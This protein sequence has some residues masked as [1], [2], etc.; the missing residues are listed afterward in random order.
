MG[1][2][3]TDDQIEEAIKALERHSPSIFERMKKMMMAT[4]LTSPL[5][6][7]QEK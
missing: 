4:T 3:H 7:E 6:D 2:F 5:N 1:D